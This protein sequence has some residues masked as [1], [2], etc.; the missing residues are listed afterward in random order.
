MSTRAVELQYGDSMLVGGA[1]I[2]LLEKSGRRA[3]FAVSAPPDVKIVHPIP[4]PSAHECAPT[5]EQGKEHTHGKYP[6]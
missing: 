1:R 2:T 6:V 3:R 4:N 5:P